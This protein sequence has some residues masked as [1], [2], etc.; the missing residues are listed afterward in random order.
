VTISVVEMKAGCCSP[1][2]MPTLVL[3]AWLVMMVLE[4]SN[5]TEPLDCSGGT[6]IMGATR[7]RGGASMGTS[8][9]TM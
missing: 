4:M 9:G 8:W 2:P 7:V 6:T 5:R 1:M 3:V